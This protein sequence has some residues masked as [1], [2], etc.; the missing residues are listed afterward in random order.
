MTILISPFNKITNQFDHPKNGWL[1]RRFT[2]IFH[3]RPRTRKSSLPKSWRSEHRYHL[4]SRASCPQSRKARWEQLGTAGNLGNMRLENVEIFSGF[5][6]WSEIWFEM[7]ADLL[8]RLTSKMMLKAIQASQVF[9]GTARLVGRG[10]ASWSWPPKANTLGSEQG[11]LGCFKQQ[12]WWLWGLEQQTWWYA[13]D[14]I[15]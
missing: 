12:V 1:P 13:G 9:Q 11:I 3:E 14:I 6:E 8:N 15:G 2:T 10:L 4:R 7:L 5:L